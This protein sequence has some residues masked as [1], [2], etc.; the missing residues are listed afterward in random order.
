MHDLALTVAKKNTRFLP[1]KWPCT[2]GNFLRGFLL[3]MMPLSE[4]WCITAMKIRKIRIDCVSH[5]VMWIFNQKCVIPTRPMWQSTVVFKYMW[6]FATCTWCIHLFISSGKIYIIQEVKQIITCTNLH[7]IIYSRRKIYTKNTKQFC[8]LPLLCRI[9]KAAF[10]Q[11]SSLPFEMSL[12]H[13]KIYIQ[14]DNDSIN[15]FRHVFIW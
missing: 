10:K 13:Y 1:T 8:F 6:I 4:D 14:N 11:V 3:A 5:M 9:S 15:I 2:A 7:H 12:S